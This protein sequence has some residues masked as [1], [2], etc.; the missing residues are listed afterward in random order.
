MVGSMGTFARG[1]RRPAALRR[2]RWAS[3]VTIAA[4]APVLRT[5]ITSPPG[6][7][8]FRRWTVVLAST[9]TAG[10]VAGSPRPLRQ[11]VR[12]ATLTRSVVRPAI[13]G[14]GAVAVF[15]AGAVVTT[16]IPLLRDRIRAVVDH[17]RHG[18]LPTVIGLALLTGVTEELFFR[19]PL[20]DAVD[21]PG[22]HPVLTSTAIYTLVTCATGNP[23][24]VFAAGVLGTITAL[25]RRATGDVIGP[26]VI[27]L[28]WSTGMLLVLPPMVHRFDRSP[29]GR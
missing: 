15:S 12:P 9:W 5:A 26:A 17:A 11:L 13:I 3:A 4:G 22:V 24:L 16:R 7:R 25:D 1:S 23:M 28:T 29:T 6:G 20:Y 8:K 18:S 14:A 2:A 19:G 27:H 21:L 10:A